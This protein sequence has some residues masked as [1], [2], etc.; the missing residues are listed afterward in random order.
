MRNI[1]L[2]ATTIIKIWTNSV[3]NQ[4]LYLQYSLSAVK[5]WLS[6]SKWQR[7]FLS[8]NR[9][10][11]G[12]IHNCGQIKFIQKMMD[13]FMDIFHSL[14]SLKLLFES[15]I[16]PFKFISRTLVTNVTGV[17]SFFNVQQLCSLCLSYWFKYIPLTPV[18]QCL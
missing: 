2:V 1:R 11:T 14:P 7:V 4:W 9:L 17:F 6:F 15:M 16:L 13:I 8:A 10:G 5:A 3:D 12:K 18:R